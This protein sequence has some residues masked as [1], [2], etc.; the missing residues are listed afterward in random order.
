MNKKTLFMKQRNNCIRKTFWEYEKIYPR[1]MA[2]AKVASEY[3]ITEDRVR[4]IV[5]EKWT[6]E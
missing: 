3:G 2:Y 6:N 1:M 4:Q 5:S